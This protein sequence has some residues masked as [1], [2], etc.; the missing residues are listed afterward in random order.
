MHLTFRCMEPLCVAQ[1][2]K[3]K[4]AGELRDRYKTHVYCRPC[5][6]YWEI[7]PH[8]V[9]KRQRCPCCKSFCRTKP[10]NGP[11]GAERYARKKAAKIESK[12]PMSIQKSIK[13]EVRNMVHNSFPEIVIPIEPQYLPLDF[14]DTEVVAKDG[15]HESV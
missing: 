4:H 3:T 14:L 12:E 10:V 13:S 6:T 11:R 15:K 9:N 8:K 1:R 7:D 5:A 2:E